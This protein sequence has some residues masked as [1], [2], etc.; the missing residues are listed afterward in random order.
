M[1]IPTYN[2]GKT[3]PV[4]VHTYNSSGTLTD[5]SD[6]VNITIVDPRGTKVIDDVSMT[7]S[8]TGTYTYNYTTGRTNIL[9][10]Y[11]VTTTGEDS[12]TFEVEKGEFK[13]EA[14]YGE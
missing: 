10:D 3:V 11:V 14:Q 5:L 1:A 9:G 12:S 7:N 13:L 2:R 6:G 8:A 4:T